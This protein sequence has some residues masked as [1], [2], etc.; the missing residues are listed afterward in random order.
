MDNY[1][2]QP[3]ALQLE[4]NLSSELLLQDP[5][6]PGPGRSRYGED[7]VKISGLHAGRKKEGPL[8]WPV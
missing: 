1:C 2:V 5:D 4:E 3:A 6:D 7:L 8:C